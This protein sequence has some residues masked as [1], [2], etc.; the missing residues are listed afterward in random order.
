V[1]RPSQVARGRYRISHKMES[2]LPVTHT[3]LRNRI[4]PFALAGCA[5]FLLVPLPPQEESTT[6]IFA[7]GALTALIIASVALVP[8]GRVSKGFQIVPVLAYFLVI[9]LLRH[10]EGGATSGY[11]TLVL[12]PIFWSALYGTRGQLAVVLVVMVATFALPIVL[13]GPPLYPAS[14]WR[15][16]LVWAGVGPVIGF[17]VQRLVAEVEQLLMLL[18]KVARTDALTKVAN[19]RAWDEQLPR[20]MARARRSNEPLS[21]AVVDLDHFKSY[22]DDRGHQAGDELLREAAA[23]WGRRIRAGD[24]LARYG[25][26]EFA[27]LLPACPASE[28]HEVVE[29]VRQAVPQGQTCSVG[30]A[31]WDGSE[32]GEN[33]LRRADEALYEAK[34]T[35]RDRTVVAA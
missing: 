22:N 9:A 5:A 35:G 20:E 19:R 6:S 28:V 13:L 27:I 11:G 18:H 31:T 23:E 34:R 33:L 29:R 8:W 4:A 3:H 10:A 1:R 2:S 7:A 14:E 17:S 24:F 25:G 26:E 16:A 32:S 30:V 15:R 12:L 21:V